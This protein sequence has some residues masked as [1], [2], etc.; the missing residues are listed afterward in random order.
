MGVTAGF[1]RA[2]QLPRVPAAAR[3]EDRDGQPQN[4]RSRTS[5]LTLPAS[6][7]RPLPALVSLPG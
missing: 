5:R 2:G 1:E 7:L 6:K 3:P 4:E